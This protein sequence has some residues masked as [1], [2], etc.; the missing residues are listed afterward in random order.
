MAP[1]NS[2]FHFTGE[3][4][5]ICICYQTY[6][7]PRGVSTCLSILYS[8]WLLF[9]LFVSRFSFLSSFSR[10]LFS[11]VS[12]VFYLVLSFLLPSHH[13]HYLHYQPYHYL[14]IYCHYLLLSANFW[15]LV[16]HNHT[17]PPLF[18]FCHSFHCETV[19]DASPTAYKHL[20][21]GIMFLMFRSLPHFA[22]KKKRLLGLSSPPPPPTK[23][24]EEKEM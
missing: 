8:I 17:N 2:T 14:N 7:F 10:V 16:S 1:Q 3:D 9:F 13:F 18:F 22:V 15:L 4:A 24:V 6:I 23:I 12:T 19:R 11:I 20:L 5:H 21:V